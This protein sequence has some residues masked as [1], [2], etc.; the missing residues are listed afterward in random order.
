MQVGIITRHTSL[1]SHQV[2]VRA[3]LGGHSAEAGLALCCE[4]CRAGRNML[5]GLLSVRPSHAG[6]HVSI[7]NK[8]TEDG[9]SFVGIDVVRRLACDR[10]KPLES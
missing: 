10:A 8:Q 7:R 9:E 6:Q 4:P 3:E 2:R 1:S 5:V